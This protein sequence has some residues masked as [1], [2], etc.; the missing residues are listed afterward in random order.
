VPWLTEQMLDFVPPNA[1]GQPVKNWVDA[2]AIAPYFYGWNPIDEHDLSGFDGD[3]VYSDTRWS[4]IDNLNEFEMAALC[5]A[6]VTR[7]NGRAMQ[8]VQGHVDACNLRGGVQ[9]ICY[10]AGHHIEASR[11]LNSSNQEVRGSAESVDTKYLS[12]NRTGFGPTYTQYL[13]ELSAATNGGL[14]CL[15]ASD[16]TYQSGRY[17]AIYE[18]Q[19]ATVAP[20]SKA[21]AAEAWIDANPQP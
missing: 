10:E 2:I 3:F 6:E 21:V 1:G 20:T 16:G 14:V 7:P 19:G 11:G 9:V 4:Q 13:D 12:L 5:L 18:R 17:W 15:F 8:W